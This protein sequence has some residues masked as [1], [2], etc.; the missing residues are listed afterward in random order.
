MNALPIGAAACLA[1]RQAIKRC[2]AGVVRRADGSL[3][4]T[5]GRVELPADDPVR[6]ETGT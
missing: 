4:K 3:H 5:D 6:L 1:C 2:E